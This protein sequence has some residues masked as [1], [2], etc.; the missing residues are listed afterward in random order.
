MCLGV[1]M[2]RFGTVQKPLT[3]SSGKRISLL[4]MA[5]SMAVVSSVALSTPTKQKASAAPY[6]GC[7]ASGYI[8]RDTGTGTDRQ[9]IDMV[10]GQGSTAGHIS[11]RQLNAIGFNPKDNKYYAW[12]L[13]NGVPVRVNDDFTNPQ[14]FTITGY[15]GPTSA[16]WSGDVDTDGYWWF[17]NAT[18]WY[19]V[20]V[21]TATPS[22]VASG[23][24]L[25]AAGTNG[26]DWAF[27]PGTNKLYRGMDEGANIRIYSFDRTTHQ[28]A[29]V[30]VVSNVLTATDGDMGSVYADPN[31]NFYMSSH[32]SGK[33]F[34][35]D[36]NDT[37][38]FTAAELDAV[39]PNSNDGARCALATVPVDFGDAPASYTTTIDDD[40]PRHSVANF[41]IAESTAPL[42][43]GTKIDVEEDG[44]PSTDA[45]GDDTNHEGGVGFV[46]DERGV[47]HLV[48]TAGSS[49][50]LTVP[51]RITNTSTQAATVAGWIDLDDDG[52]F[53]VSE[54]VTQTVAAGFTGYVQLAFPAPP[55]PYNS[56]TFARF[57]VFSAGD[58]SDA[59]TN[60][61]PTGAASGGE[62]EDVHVQLGTYSVTKSAN[63]AEGNSVDSGSNVTYTLTIKNTGAT[64]LNNLKI[65]DDLTDVLDDATLVGAPVVTPSSAGSATVTGDTL[66]FAGDLTAGQ[67]VTVAYTVKIKDSGTLGNAALNNYVLA[68]H[69][70]TCHPQVTNGDAGVSNPDCQTSHPVNGLANTGANVTILTIVSG[71]LI[72]LAAVLY[73]AKTTH[74]NSAFRSR[75]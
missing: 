5:V 63:P 46:D 12:D 75:L 29:A 71:G 54:R 25:P 15:A 49:D 58:I 38:P 26:T 41:N 73:S 62:V 35:V 2:R 23:T 18:H 10:T 17:F 56:D 53:E 33:L 19:Q 59:A 22:L 51:V 47:T 6:L 37:A 68:A 24:D 34:R 70:T 65:D 45:D 28:Y 36:L 30:G 20:D 61:A 32:N 44:F 42:M 52:T 48:A 8:V 74:R 7:S 40:G 4:V 11:G 69:S 64:G 67:A 13:Q 39:D 66:E 21:N 16:I 57:R 27:V 31:N 55:A 43:L 72:A 3:F 60:L 50:P 1:N 14:P 9:A